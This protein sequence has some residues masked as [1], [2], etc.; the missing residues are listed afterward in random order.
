ME[1]PFVTMLAS[2]WPGPYLLLKDSA[3]GYGSGGQLMFKAVGNA[4][5]G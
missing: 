3:M 1:N 5:N 4:K 2:I